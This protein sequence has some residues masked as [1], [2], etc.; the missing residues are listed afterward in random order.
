MRVNGEWQAVTCHFCASGLCTDDVG[1]WTGALSGLGLHR[2]GG[3]LQCG[4]DQ[5]GEPALPVYPP[6]AQPLERQQEGADQQRR[7]GGL[8]D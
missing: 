4:V 5:E 6:A 7:T 3:G 8:P 2:A 1:H